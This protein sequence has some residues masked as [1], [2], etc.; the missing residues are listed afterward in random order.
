MVRV[1]RLQGSS[2]EQRPRTAAR[3]SP[4]R[5]SLRREHLSSACCLLV[6]GATQKWDTSSPWALSRRPGSRARKT[7]FGQP[8]TRDQGS[9]RR[10]GRAA[11]NS[12][13]KVTLYLD[14]PNWPRKHWFGLRRM[15]LMHL[16]NFTLASITLAALPWW[17]PR[18][19]AGSSSDWLLIKKWLISWVRGHQR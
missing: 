9:V 15:V 5:Q 6:T 16:S 4:C 2:G 3:L 19:G 8:A 1:A 14:G 12:G 13:F 7:P 10:G 17:V 18:V 11:G